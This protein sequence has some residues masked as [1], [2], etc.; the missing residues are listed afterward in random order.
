MLITYLLNL[1]TYMLAYLLTYL[2]A[3]YGGGTYTV[4]VD[5]STDMHTLQAE[6]GHEHNSPNITSYSPDVARNKR[7]YCLQRKI[8]KF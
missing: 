2:R 8:S 7:T 5:M 6:Y 1:L 4:I 3:Q